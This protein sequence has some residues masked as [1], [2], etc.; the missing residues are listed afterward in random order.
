MAEYTPTTEE[1]ANVFECGD[2]DETFSSDVYRVRA[3]RRKQF[4]EWLAAHDAEVRASVVT[5]EPEWA[6]DYIQYGHLLDIGVFM[7]EP[8][9]KNYAT[10]QRRVKLGHPE[11][12][13]GPVKQGDET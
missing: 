4:Y 2:D 9:G 7:V 1:I 6:E 11:S 8:R 12:A 10:H 5:E 13:W 3:K